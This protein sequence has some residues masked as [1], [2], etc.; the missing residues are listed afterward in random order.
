M[1]LQQ[2]WRFVVYALLTVA[3]IGALLSFCVPAYVESVLIPGLA[4]GF[5][6][7]PVACDVRRIGL[8]GADI[9]SFT[10]G[11]AGRPILSADAVQVDY[12]LIQLAR[13][14]IKKANLSGLK[15]FCQYGSGGLTIPGLDAGSVLGRMHSGKK[16]SGVSN[17]TAVLPFGAIELR[18]AVLVCDWDGHIFRLPMDLQIVSEAT[19]NGRLV[20]TLRL[21]P[22]DQQ[23]SAVIDVDSNDKTAVLRF[24]A[25]GFQ[26]EPFGDFVRSIPGLAVQGSVNVGGTVG[27]RLDP[28]ELGTGSVSCELVSAGVSYKGLEAGARGAQEAGKTRPVLHLQG[29]GGEWEASVSSI[30]VATPVPV[31]VA[32]IRFLF[33]VGTET[34]AGSGAFVLSIDAAEGI[35]SL[36]VGLLGPLACQGRFSVSRV[37]TGG[38][39]FDV[40]TMNDEQG[41]DA[42]VPRWKCAVGGLE[43]SSKPPVL[44]V[45][46]RGGQA[47]GCVTVKAA[48]ADLAVAGPDV[49]ATIPSIAFAGS[50][51]WGRPGNDV[52]RLTLHLS[53]AEVLVDSLRARVGQAEGVG[54]L[55]TSEAGG[56]RL[57]GIVKIPDGRFVPATEGLALGG[58]FSLVG[59]I[60]AGEPNAKNSVETRLTEGMVVWKEH[61]FKVEGLNVGLLIADLMEM[62]SAPMQHL[63]FRQASFG[64]LTVEEGE[65]D[66]QIASSDSMVVERGRVQWCGGQVHVEAMQI[67]AANNSYDVVLYCD[68]LNLATVLEQLGAARVKGDGTVSGRIPL[69]IE[70]GRLVFGNGFLFSSPGDGGTIRLRGTEALTAGIPPGTPQYVQFALAEEALKDF[71]YEWAKVTLMTEGNDLVAHLELDGK[72][73]QP[74]PFV[75]NKEL[76]FFARAEAGSQGSV[77]QGIKLDV[78]FRLPINE[79]LHYGNAVGK[80]VGGGRENKE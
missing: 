33:T 20:C 44:A 19:E 25:N 47:E 28:L 32:N 9:G 78:H 29:H 50:L 12:G 69:R 60:V 80:I 64:T 57:G 15:V 18:N 39:T 37:K 26:L 46:G 36:G 5:G 55:E 23:V 6:L 71:E 38:W 40:G 77:F 43:I 53:D 42:H 67:A 17:P 35:G 79:L 66:F 14:R 76:G 48:L 11:E 59:R 45:S 51:P 34:I 73:V 16:S 31:K 4:A 13:G 72:P 27:L 3:L 1:T 24:D 52:S 7:S 68:R 2:K 10:V 61:G 58:N 70:N 49:R 21:Y 54:Q 22:R 74:L 65:A 8:T 30:W 62:R 41:G 75:F 63:H 56:W